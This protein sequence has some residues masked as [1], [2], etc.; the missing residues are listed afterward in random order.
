M[1]RLERSFEKQAGIAKE[2]FNKAYKDLEGSFGNQ[3][4]EPTNALK[5]KEG[6]RSGLAIH[7]GPTRNGALRATFGCLR[8]D[9]DTAEML[10]NAAVDTIKAGRAVSYVCEEVP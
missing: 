1:H 6:G 5:A 10:A 8:V 7:G 4:F 2:P 3:V 9:D